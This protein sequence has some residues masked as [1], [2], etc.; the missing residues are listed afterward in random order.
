MILVTGGTG[1]VGSHLL[2]SLT[3]END[4][5]KAIY[6][7]EEKLE[8]VKNVFSF[9]TDDFLALF[10][11]I[12]WIKADITDVPSL[13]NVFDVSI[14]HVY[15]CAAIVSFDRKD[16]YKM[17][18]TNIEGTANIVNFCIEYNIKKLCHVSSIAT[19]G[20]AI[21]GKMVSEEN[22]WND[23]EANHGYA[24]T[25]YGA[26]MEVWRASQENVDM[27]IV[28]PGVIL[29]AGFFNE[30][31]GKMFTQVYNGFKFYTEGVTG[32]V[33]VGDVV[34]TMISLMKSD[35]KNERFVLVSENK[36]FKDILCLIAD[37]FNKKQPSI[38]IGG[39]ITAVFWRLAWL[40]SKITGKEPLLT[41]NSAKSA[42]QKEF[43][44]SEKIEKQLHFDFEKMDTVIKG[45]CNDYSLS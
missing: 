30:G 26:E 18:K 16:Y 33:G 39:F 2:Y 9:Y 36:S 8:K 42:H 5:I 28:N 31:S 14:T 35:T 6:R 43:Y 25:K 38:K 4:T 3:K 22:E 21:G 15:H 17:R 45:I 20:D 23:Q 37:A 24:I 13:Y 19:L 11:K 44:T 1:L 40:L 7:S 12:Q 27:V 32:F 34:K 10:N 29:G 41:K